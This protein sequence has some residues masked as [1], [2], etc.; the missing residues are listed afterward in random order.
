MIATLELSA[1]L[2]ERQ[3]GGSLVAIE[4]RDM[5]QQLLKRPPAQIHDAEPCCGAPSYLGVHHRISW[6]VSI[7]PLRGGEI[8]VHDG[9][10]SGH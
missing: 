4:R 8:V 10:V 9:D 7:F 6:C 5:L 3:L 2:E 1:R